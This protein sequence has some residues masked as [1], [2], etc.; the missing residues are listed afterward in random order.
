M[1]DEDL[2]WTEVSLLNYLPVPTKTRPFIC[3]MKLCF[4][5]EINLKVFWCSCFWYLLSTDEADMIFLTWQPL[6]KTHSTYWLGEQKEFSLPLHFIWGNR[7]LSPDGRGWSMQSNTDLALR[8]TCWSKIVDR[9]VC[10]T[11]IDL[12][13]TFTRGNVRTDSINDLLQHG[14]QFP[15]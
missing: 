6:T 1:K 3:N 12:P 7:N 5:Q 15:R 4:I 11:P 14:H 13:A 2:E 10:G 9:G 8:R